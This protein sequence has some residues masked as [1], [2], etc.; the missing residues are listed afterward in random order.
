MKRTRP[1]RPTSVNVAAKRS[2]LADAATAPGQTAATAAPAPAAAAAAAAT[3]ATPTAAAAAA[4][5]A[6]AAASAASVGELDARLGGSG[7]FLVEDIKRRQTDVGDFFFPERDFMVRCGL[8]RR[9]I[10]SR[11]TRGRC[12][13]S[14]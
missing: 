9:D 7:V 2:R 13:S 12:G 1:Q 3:T 11:T 4:T 14:R 5:T 8:V 6:A 10:P